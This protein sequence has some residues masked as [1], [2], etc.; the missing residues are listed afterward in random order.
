MAP[1]KSLRQFEFV[2]AC[3]SLFNLSYI[4][5]CDC[6]WVF[7]NRKQL[8]LRDWIQ[9]C[10]MFQQ[11]ESTWD[12]S[13]V[14]TSF[15]SFLTDSMELPSSFKENS[16][17]K[18]IRRPVSTLDFADGFEWVKAI[19]RDFN[20]TDS[21][22]LREILADLTLDNCGEVVRAKQDIAD[23]NASLLHE[24]LL[25]LA[26]VNTRLRNGRSL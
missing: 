7:G 14:T 15:K 20:R 13:S 1:G 11:S 23:S 8:S 26:R 6:L 12:T 3:H 2:K 24:E 18:T 16:V 25:R 5:A 9:I 22:M 19:T 17:T 10:E 4:D 21:R